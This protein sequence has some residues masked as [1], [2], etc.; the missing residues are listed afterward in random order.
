MSLHLEWKSCILEPY[1]HQARGWCRTGIQEG[2]LPS[3]A[4]C[5]ESWARVAPCVH[6]VPFSPTDGTRMGAH[7]PQDHA[8][9]TAPGYKDRP[10]PSNR[11]RIRRKHFWEVPYLSAIWEKKNKMGGGFWVLGDPSLLTPSSP[12]FPL[13]SHNPYWITAQ[14][15][16]TTASTSNSQLEPWLLW[17]LQEGLNS[18]SLEIWPPAAPR[19]DNGPCPGLHGNSRARERNEGKEKGGEGEA[20]VGKKRKCLTWQLALNLDKP[21]RALHLHWD[22]PSPQSC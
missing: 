19:E 6:H 12:N 17:K 2:Y 15:L 8:K 20:A 13:T 14:A 9:L 11:S 7:N 22:T 1:N 16:V 21:S 18:C 5:G 10:S 4:G 3:R